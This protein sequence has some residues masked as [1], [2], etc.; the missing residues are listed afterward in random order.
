MLLGPNYHAEDMCDW[1]HNATCFVFFVPPVFAHQGGPC[2]GEGNYQGQHELLS[3]S[4]DF[5]QQK[6]GWQGADV[7]DS[8][9][10]RRCF[11]SIDGGV[12]D[13]VYL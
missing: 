8:H 9:G 4:T 12:N 5:E 7:D 1:I 11:I 13:F 2:L 3:V 6:L 10:D